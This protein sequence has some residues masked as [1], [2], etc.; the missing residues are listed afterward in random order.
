MTE[1]TIENIAIELN[2]KAAVLSSGTTITQFL[3]AKGLQDRLVVVELNGVI[4]PRCAFSDTRFSGGD[5][6]EV[7]HFVGGG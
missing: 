7:V 4:V 6:V 3:A 2:G 1:K 5:K